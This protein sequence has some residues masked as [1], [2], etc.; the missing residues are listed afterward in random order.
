MMFLLSRESAGFVSHL[1]VFDTL[2]GAK[3]FE[4]AC[5]KCHMNGLYTYSIKPVAYNLRA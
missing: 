5:L 3:A 4:R 1:G 2:E